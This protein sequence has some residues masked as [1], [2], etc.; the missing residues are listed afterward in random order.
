MFLKC[1]LTAEGRTDYK[2]GDQTV[3]QGRVRM[4]ETR[5][6]TVEADEFIVSAVEIRGLDGLMDWQESRVSPRFPV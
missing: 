6:E 4:T 5:V 1:A 2:W 3:I